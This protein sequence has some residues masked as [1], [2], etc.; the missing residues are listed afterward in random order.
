MLRTMLFMLMS[1]SVLAVASGQGFPQGDRPLAPARDGVLAGHPPSSAVSCGYPQVSLSPDGEMFLLMSNAN[2]D[3]PLPMRFGD[4]QSATSVEGVHLVGSACFLRGGLS[5]ECLVGRIEVPA[6]VAIAWWSQDSRHVFANG[7]G[8]MAGF[9]I[10]PVARRVT[11]VG[12]PRNDLNAWYPSLAVAG[13]TPSTS[14]EQEWQRFRDAL[15]WLRTV[16]RPA[17]GDSP[18]SLMRVTLRPDGMS[19]SG[20]LRGSLDLGVIE[21]APTGIA[22][23]TGYRVTSF[24]GEERPMVVSDEAG[25]L[26]A[27][28][29]GE[30]IRRAKGAVG[31]SAR[32][33]QGPRP[34]LFGKRPILDS[35]SGRLLGVHT[36][37]EIVW[38]LE[39]PVLEGFRA[40]V[41]RA[42]PKDAV[43]HAVEYS[44]KSDVAIV[45][46]YQVNVGLTRLVFARDSRSG[47]WRSGGT[48]CPSTSGDR[49]R[50]LLTVHG[51]D[52]GERDW[53]VMARHY[54][55]AGS[56]RLV[57]LLHGGPNR[58]VLYDDVGLWMVRSG[59]LSGKSEDL[60][61][62]DPSGSGGVDAT[63]ADRLAVF[64]GAALERDADLIA[65]DALRLA[66]SYD[67]VVLQVSSYGGALLPDVASRLGDR[68]IRAYVTAPLMQHRGYED[69]RVEQGHDRLM[70]NSGSFKDT[71]Q[72]LYYGLDRVEGEKRFDV[73]LRDRYRQFRPDHRFVFVFGT[74]DELSRPTDLPNPGSARLVVLEGGHHVPHTELGPLCWVSGDCP[75]GTFQ[76]D[77]SL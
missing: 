70:R 27:V 40:S 50:P 42:L 31:A 43:L 76:A 7:G 28:G 6:G 51:Y 32:W 75:P 13:P 55:R 47:R 74:L 52:A 62:Y 20:T 69:L 57:V 33:Q 48:T 18:F 19:A 37:R 53:P 2:F 4:L 21:S 58:S 24:G 68:M 29:E 22:M 73:W 66:K 44:R 14:S 61:S 39:A 8:R 63:V 41:M 56:R 16:T 9:K 23:P 35:S 60:V 30:A 38:A 59:S 25:H 15:G 1:L 26:W 64:G 11:M 46:F 3:F 72:R 34:R 12:E 65:R 71:F 77:G 10:D 67:E 5:Q 49:G 36:E 45:T 17:V 54:S